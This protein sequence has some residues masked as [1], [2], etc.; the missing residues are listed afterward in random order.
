M[1][2]VGRGQLNLELILWALGTEPG[3]SAKAA[4]ASNFLAISPAEAFH[5]YIENL[6]VLPQI[7]QVSIVQRSTPQSSFSSLSA[8]CGM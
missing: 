2:K 3:S 7:G 1:Y 4:S 8:L 5:F 6:C